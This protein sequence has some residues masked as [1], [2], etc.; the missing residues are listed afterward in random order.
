MQFSVSHPVMPEIIRADMQ[1]WCQKEAALS[2][3]AR[4]LQC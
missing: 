3:A 4:K 2:P 1:K